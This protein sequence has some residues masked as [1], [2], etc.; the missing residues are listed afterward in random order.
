MN[1]G[2][3]SVRYARALLKSADQQAVKDAVYAD[4]QSIAQNYLDVRQLRTAIDNPM[5]PKDK[6][7]EILLAACGG[8][9]SEQ[10]K[11][12]IKLVLNEGRENLMQFMANSFVTLYRQ[13]KNMVSGHTHED[14]ADGGEAYS[15][16]RR[17]RDRGEPRHYW[18]LHTRV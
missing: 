8:N 2:V 4:M 6:K 18:W 13:E 11:K 9:P 15:G 5:L 10:T 16:K 7:E 14:A 3:I 1:T 17:V 12:F